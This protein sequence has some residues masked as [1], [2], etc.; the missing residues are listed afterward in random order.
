MYT[1]MD[2]PKGR[3]PKVTVMITDDTLAIILLEVTSCLSD[4]VDIVYIIVPNPKI[5][6]SNQYF[7]RMYND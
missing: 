2:A 4:T 1:P 6:Q 3:A 5:K 7:S